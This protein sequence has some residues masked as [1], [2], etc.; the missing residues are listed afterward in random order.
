MIVVQGLH[1][2]LNE[3]TLGLT[4]GVTLQRVNSDERVYPMIRKLA[5]N[6]SQRSVDTKRLL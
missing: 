3:P 5:R 4:S 2:N 1:L 6:L